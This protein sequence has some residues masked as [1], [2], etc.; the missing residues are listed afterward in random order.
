MPV[1]GHFDSIF[2]KPGKQNPEKPSCFQQFNCVPEQSSRILAGKQ[3]YLVSNKVKKINKI[4]SVWNQT[5]DWH[6]KKQKKMSHNLR[7][8]ISWTDT[9]HHRLENSYYNYIS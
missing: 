8:S 5:K 9:E 1:T 2:T 7:K 4:H 6:E 3:K